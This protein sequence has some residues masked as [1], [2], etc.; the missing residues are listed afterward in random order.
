MKL[1]SV[2]KQ[3]KKKDAD[4]KD[5]LKYNSVKVDVL[6]FC[7]KYILSGETLIVEV[8]PSVMDSFLQ[9][10]QSEEFTRKYEFQQLEDNL[11]ALRLKDLMEF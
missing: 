9:Y 2:L 4:S 7:E 5:R 8:T 6:Q 3:G 10:A 1:M 11:V